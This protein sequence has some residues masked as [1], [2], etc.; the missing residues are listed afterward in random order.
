MN[1]RPR[2]AY[3]GLLAL[4]MALGAYS[5]NGSPQDESAAAGATSGRVTPQ[6]SVVTR[7]A[8]PS[9]RV[10]AA[11]ETPPRKKQARSNAQ[12]RR[13]EANRRKQQAAALAKEEEERRAAEERQRIAAAR[14]SELAALAARDYADGRL[15]EP[16]GNNAADRYQAALELDPTQPEALAGAKRI[17]SILAA[18]A[19]R[20]A[21]AGD[22]ERTQRYITR[23]RVLQPKDESLLE[24]EARAAALRASPVVLSERQQER[25][26]RSAESIER[27]HE[28]LRRKPLDRQAINLAVNEHDRAAS[29]VELAPGLPMLEDRIMLAFPA[30]TRT[31]LASDNPKGALKIVE[32]ARERGWFNPELALLESTA[33]E[34]LAAKKAR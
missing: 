31:E 9:N 3:T 22:R 2:P 11:E 23:I 24:L 6:P 29:L 16:P 17:I 13:A 14:A 25:Y 18:E 21:I 7:V 28:H 15:L 5:A 30:A 26:S 33:R 20:S 4:L 27:A 19:E 8:A 10:A 34:S 12:K 1:R 32:L